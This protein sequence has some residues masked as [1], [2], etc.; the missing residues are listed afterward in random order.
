MSILLAS[1]SADL[2]DR[3]HQATG[4]RLVV[5]SGPA[6]ADPGPLLEQPGG[7]PDIVLLDTR[8]GTEQCLELAAG[9]GHQSP[10]TSVVLLSA[11]APRIGLLALRA[12]A[13][14]VV[15]PDADV[16]ELTQAIDRAWQLARARRPLPAAPAAAAIAAVGAGP[17]APADGGRV[18]SVLS[19]KGGVGKT[20][21]ATNLAVGLARS[22]H[23]TVLVDL[24]VQFGDVASALNLSPEYSLS[25][26][27]R[28]GAARDAM[29]L[30]TLLARHE[31]GLFVLCAPESPAA[32]DDITGADVD[33]LLRVL[34]SEFSYVVVDTAPGLSE[35][36]LAAADQ[37]TD[38]VL[39]TSMDVPG[40]RGLR[41]ELDTLTQLGMFL[42]A[43]HV[44]LNFTDAR[45]GLSVGDIEATIGTGVDVRLPRSAAVQA[46]VNEGVPLL[47]S[48]RRDPMTSQ[49]HRLVDLFT[50]VPTLVAEPGRRRARHRGVRVGSR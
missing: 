16:A 2:T 37:T 22:G 47:Q 11:D 15:H 3:V 13:C 12:G 26:V 17:A 40:V 18:I 20:T 43:R 9:L 31:T 4:G 34:A 39:L 5:L 24:D 49:L 44:V 28:S 41:K 30:K 35:H 38:P 33:G 23:A 42:D 7:P 46:S 25:D 8:L 10:G 50:P 45:G 21:V 29:A 1:A 32:A 19:P 36:T 48:G 6:P 14:D 27:V